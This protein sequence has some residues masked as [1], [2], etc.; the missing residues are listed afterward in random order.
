MMVT[1][2]TNAEIVVLPSLPTCEVCCPCCGY[3]LFGGAHEKCPECGAFLDGISEQMSGIRKDW[4]FELNHVSSVFQYLRLI[5]HRGFWPICGRDHLCAYAPPDARGITFLCVQVIAAVVLTGFVAVL[6]PMFSNLQIRMTAIDTNVLENKEWLSNPTNATEAERIM[7]HG[8]TVDEYLSRKPM[9]PA[10][11]AILGNEILYT[12]Q[13]NK[14]NLRTHLLS[15]LL[16]LLGPP[17]VLAMVV[18]SPIWGN[19]GCRV[20]R[21]HIIKLVCCTSST[22]FVVTLIWVFIGV[23]VASGRCA[24]FGLALVEIGAVFAIILFVCRV[25]VAWANCFRTPM[26]RAFSWTITL[27]FVLPLLR[28]CAMSLLRASMTAG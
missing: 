22:I 13:T 14:Q 21:R 5:F 17:L 28:C 26:P 6:M 16:C 18:R 9:A 8:V 2:S 1:H 11:W 3:S 25:R 4:L 20:L 23:I 24:W 10:Y 27:V 19:S 7:G 12:I 15:Y